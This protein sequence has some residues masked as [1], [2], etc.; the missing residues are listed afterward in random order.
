MLIG[1]KCYEEKTGNDEK[2]TW[3]RR[4]VTIQSMAPRTDPLSEDLKEGRVVAHAIWERG[5]L[6]MVSSAQVPRQVPVCAGKTK[7]PRW[8]SGGG[9]VEMRGGPILLEV[10]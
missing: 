4:E 3:G 5:F 7:R 1:D 10:T 2:G 9:S 8:E 6:A